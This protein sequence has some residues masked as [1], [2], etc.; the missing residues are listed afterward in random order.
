MDIINKIVDK[1]ADF[2]AKPATW[3]AAMLRMLGFL[4][5]GLLAIEIGWWAG[6][7]FSVGWTF[8]YAW[9]ALTVYGSMRKR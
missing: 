2:V 1:I 6:V 5:L 9:G 4:A 8:G 3:P 7:P